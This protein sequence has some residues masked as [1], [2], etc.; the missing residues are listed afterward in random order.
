MKKT[1]KNRNY[2]AL[3][4]AIGIL[5]GAVAIFDSSSINKQEFDFTSKIKIEANMETNVVP[6]K[7]ASCHISN[8]GNISM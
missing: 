4:L 5:I 6:E 7:A 2:E 3:I 1:P 8:Q